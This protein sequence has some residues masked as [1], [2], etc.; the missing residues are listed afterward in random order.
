MLSQNVRIFDYDDED[1]QYL[2]MKSLYVPEDF[3][4]YDQQAKFDRRIAKIE[5]FDFSTYGPKGSAF[6][7]YLKDNDLTVKNFNLLEN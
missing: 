2:F 4:S 7:N 6:D 1:R 3:D 5:N